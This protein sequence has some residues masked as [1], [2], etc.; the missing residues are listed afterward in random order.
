MNINY[1]PESVT[2][3]GM[4]TA[5]DL[6][7]P[8]LKQVNKHPYKTLG[9]Y[10]NLVVKAINLPDE[11]ASMRYKTGRHDFIIK[12]RISWALTELKTGGLISSIKQKKS[13][14]FITDFGKSMLNTPL[15][16]EI[17]YNLKQ[18]QVNSQ[19]WEHADVAEKQVQPSN[20]KLI[21]EIQKLNTQES[22][23]IKALQTKH[24]QQIKEKLLE[25]LYTID[26]YK[27]EH[28][29][30]K[31]LSSMGYKGVNADAI[32]TAK[33]G[34]N[35]IDGIISRD[36]LGFDKIYIQVKRYNKD[37]HVSRPEIDA[38]VGALRRMR[39]SASHS[40]FVTTSTFT[41]GALEAAREA[42]ILTMDGVKL[43]NYLVEYH[44][45]VE[46][47]EYT[48]FNIDLDYFK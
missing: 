26:P 9:I 45:G 23:S 39:I 11:L 32:T 5:Y 7:S 12:K 4:P 8:V 38:F 42:G 29:I 22:D 2:D 6:L 48:F 25:Q 19:S 13:S 24:N 15:N 41:P 47:K 27:L 21:H 36:V 30:V 33:V 3:K 14:Y 1:N 43:V 20:K 34:D 16:K 37:N 28:I 10:T 40:I 44:V 46:A 17:L 35:G 18:H 31:L